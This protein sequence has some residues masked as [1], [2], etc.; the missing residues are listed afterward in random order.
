MVK[1]VGPELTYTRTYAR[2]Y[3]RTYAQTYV[4]KYAQE[5]IYRFLP[6]SKDI[7]GTKK[8]LVLIGQ[9]KNGGPHTSIFLLQIYCNNSNVKCKDPCIGNFA[10]KCNA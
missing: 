2:T 10:R 8:D 6:E 7:R 4:C 3:V 9:I 1:A 5:R